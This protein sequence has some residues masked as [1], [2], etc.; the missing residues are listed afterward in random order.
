MRGHSI[1]DL[2]DLRSSS[3]SSLIA[4]IAALET[5]EA[6]NRRGAAA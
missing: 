6:D 1:V 3:G 2:H 4:A 5:S